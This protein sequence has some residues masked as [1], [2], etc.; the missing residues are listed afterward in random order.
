[1]AIVDEFGFVAFFVKAYVILG[2]AASPSLHASANMDSF[3]D[4]VLLRISEFL[5]PEDSARLSQT[6]RRL[7]E[8]LPR[9]LVMYG[10]DFSVR[11]PS[12]E[13][14]VKHGAPPEFYFDGPTLPTGVKSMHL[15]IR[16]KDQGWGNLKGE[17]FVRLMRKMKETP[18]NF[19]QIAEKRR[20]FGI[21]GHRWCD[22][23]AKLSENEAVVSHTQAGDFYRFMR[24]VGGG[25]GHQLIVKRFRVIATLSKY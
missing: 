16:W 22:A 21:A 5:P 14:S 10:E 25:G 4:V 12:Y 18:E 11:G 17:I 7:Y 6:C 1:M 2:G 13:Q 20:V 3:P 9:F 24:N 8:L 23:K 19:E 15:S